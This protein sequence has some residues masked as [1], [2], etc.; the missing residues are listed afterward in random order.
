MASVTTSD[1]YNEP[2]EERLGYMRA[3]AETFGNGQMPRA[4]WAFCVVAH[5][6]RLEAFSRND[7]QAQRFLEFFLR[8]ATDACK[9]LVVSVPVG[10]C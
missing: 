1:D 9:S 6:R 5:I 2:S 7:A 4:L 3:I 10:C 8:D